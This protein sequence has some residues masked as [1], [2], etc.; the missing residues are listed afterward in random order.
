MLLLQIPL[1]HRLL[2]H[3]RLLLHFHLLR[4]NTRPHRPTLYKLTQQLPLSTEHFATLLP[5]RVLMRFFPWLLNISK[6]R[7]GGGG[8][9]QVSH[10][11]DIPTGLL[12]LWHVLR[13]PSTHFGK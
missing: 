10:H 8:W 6:L 3:R 7:S 9:V 1:L 13:P 2:R 11:T 5:L 12:D 4:P